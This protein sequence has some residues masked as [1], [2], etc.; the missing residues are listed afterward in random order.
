MKERIAKLL[1]WLLLAP[2]VLPLLY[3]DG[4]LYPYLAPKILLLRGLGIGVI[5]AIL[6]LLCSGVPLF[7]KRLRSPWTWVPGLLLIVAYSTS[8]LGAD[9]YRSFWSTF[10]RGDGLLTLSVCVAFFYA[11]LLYVQVAH[12]KKIYTAAAWVGTLVAGYALLQ[13]LQLVSGADFL[14]IESAQG[15][16]G[17]TFG[18]A[19]FLAAYLGITFF[20]TIAAA[21]TYTNWR[22]TGAYISAGLQVAVILLT[23]TRGTLLALLVAAFC[24]L[25][26]VAFDQK[27]TYKKVARG[28][29]VVLLGLASVF[30]T[31]RA[32]LAEVP[33]EPIKRV[34]SI[35]LTE[36]TVSSR[37][38]VWQHLLAKG[39]ERPLVGYGA[40]QIAPLFNQ[41][42]DPGL[43]VEQWFDRSHN[44]FLDYFV[45]YGLVGLFLYVALIVGVIWQGWRR[46]AERFGQMLMLV[47]VVYAVQNFFVFDTAVT[48]WLLLALYAAAL[49]EHTIKPQAIVVPYK[50][51]SAPFVGGALLLLLV[52]VCIQPLRANWALAE[53]YVYQVADVERY[54]DTMERGLALHTYADLEYGY[55]VYSLYTEQQ[56]PQLSG[57]PRVQVYTFAR[58]LL[59]KNF[60]RYPYD[61]RTAVYLAHVIDTA[62]P[63]VAID[64]AQLHAVLERAIVLS[65]KR[66]QSQ[67]LL[68]NI[69][70]RK[71]DAAKDQKAKNAAYTEAIV[72]LQKYAAAV[73][74]FSDPRFI[75][76]NLYLVLQN[77][78]E[79][80]KWASEGLAIYVGNPEVAKHAAKYYIAVED[81]PHAA[82]FLADVLGDTPTN[83]P[84]LYDYAK[85]VFLTGDKAKAR[86][87]VDLL[88]QKSPG[89]VETDPTF[90]SALSQP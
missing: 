65:P 31:F 75:I 73:P 34:A 10:E 81:W 7:W 63:E 2:L 16:I 88:R 46:R 54:L 48:F 49:V 45:Q 32:Q 41:V 50:K 83:Y 27:N 8:L 19:A 9:F 56:L 74:K 71:G 26:Y 77:K 66:A 36:G 30:F 35:S 69:A 86:Q 25:L 37:L 57:A 68:S 85:V 13:W 12:L 17:G 59:L 44:A 55:Q 79:A 90:L 51:Y 14:F 18:N 42:Y 21:P 43:I 84:V 52:P 47:G 53:G 62:P 15:R 24:A 80:A 72:Q 40:E 39:L 11:T 67:Y 38:F 29:L 60:E 6:Y 76:A 28:G 70:L 61:A 1:S 82:L 33:F 23:A 20:A 4:L 5:A 89:L 22:R 78:T 64:E 87:I 58:D 3:M